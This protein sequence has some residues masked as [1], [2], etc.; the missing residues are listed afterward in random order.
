MPNPGHPT[1][2][3]EA[4]PPRGALLALPQRTTPAHKSV[5]SGVGGG[6]LVHSPGAHREK[7]CG[8]RLHAPRT[9]AWGR[10]IAHSRTPLQEG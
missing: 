4:P 10:E 3:H 9:G 8:P 7:S 2:R 1:R 5:R 6:P